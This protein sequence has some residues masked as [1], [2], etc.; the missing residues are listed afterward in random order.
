MDKLNQKY[1]K[2]N[3]ALG[4]LDRAIKTFTLFAQEGKSYNP[5]IDY[6]EEYRG[7][8]DSMVQRFEYCV[9]LYWKYLKKYLEEI[10]A[11]KVIGPKPIIK[12]SFAA[13]L[14]NEHEAELSMMMIE[15]RN[16]TSHMYVEEVAETLA[17]RIPDYYKLMHVIIQRLKPS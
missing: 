7:L 4:T 2:I 1:Q 6:E 3:Q 11:L 5:H 10:V 9:D 14:I 12:E 15:D 17:K 16:I 13:E 8:R